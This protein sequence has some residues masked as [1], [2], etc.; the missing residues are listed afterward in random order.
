VQ[1]TEFSV[2]LAVGGMVDQLIFVADVL[3]DLLEN[4]PQFAFEAEIKP[5]AVGAGS[6][7]SHLGKARINRLDAN[8]AGQ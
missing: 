6:K 8:Q 7:G 3:I 1:L 5:L 4:I 2:L